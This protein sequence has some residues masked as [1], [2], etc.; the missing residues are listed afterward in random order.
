MLFNSLEFVMFFV[1]VYAL[2]LAL[3][4]RAQNRMLLVASWIFYG[5]WDWRFLSL[6]IIS[7]VV[8]YYVSNIIFRTENP[9]HRK[10]WLAVSIALSLSLLGFFKYF[11]FFAG[12]FRALMARFGIAVDLPVLNIVLPVGISFYTFQTMSYVIDVYR[13]TIKPAGNFWDFA[14]FVAFF[15]QLVAG[16]I[17]RA[18]NLLRHVERPRTVTWNGVMEG[19]F[20]MLW[21]LFQKVVVADNL[22]RI[23]NPVFASHAPYN[24]VA[25]LLA[26]YAFLIQIYCDFAGYSNIAR[27]LASCMGFN[28]MVNF[29]SP[30][31]S[32][33]PTEFWTRWHISLSTW[34]RDYLFLPLTSVFRGPSRTYLNLMLTMTLAGLWHGAAWTFVLWGGFHGLML[35]TH[36]FWKKSVA[37]YLPAGPQRGFGAGALKVFNIMLLFNFVALSGLLFRGQSMEQVGQMALGLATNLVLPG[38]DWMADTLKAMLLF[39]LPLMIVDFMQYRSDDQLVVLRWPVPVRAAVYV[40]LFYSLTIFGVNYGQ[41]FIYFQF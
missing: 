36:R 18:G 34:L 2:Y 35:V 20:L 33:S 41:D 25:V 9:R 39:V 27:G 12:S 31:L 22:A 10:A 11:N 6:L 30:L 14:L 23:V 38:A 7:S 13:R 17:E 19:A 3:G 1:L 28:L 24:G 16:P 26:L 32:A 8:D 37:R 4:H 29:R 5:A 40:V 15:P 21:G